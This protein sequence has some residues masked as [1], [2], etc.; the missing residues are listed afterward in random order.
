VNL[1][2]NAKDAMPSGGRLTFEVGSTEIEE[3]LNDLGPDEVEAGQYV[4]LRVRDTGTGMD[5]DVLERAFDPFFTTK[6]TGRGTGLGLAT[7][8]GAVHQSEGYVQVSSVPGEGTSFI[9]YLPRA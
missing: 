8:Y 6:E 7:V 2:V 9:L 3:T 1:A 5:P 4:T